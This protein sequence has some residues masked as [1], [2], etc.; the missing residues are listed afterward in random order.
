MDTISA[1]LKDERDTTLVATIQLRREKI[2]LSAKNHRLKEEAVQ[3]FNDAMEA[4]S[5]VIATSKSWVVKAFEMMAE[6]D[7]IPRYE[8]RLALV[9]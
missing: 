5:M 6:L 8:R 1:E 7:D 9:E 3:A 2:I 4:L